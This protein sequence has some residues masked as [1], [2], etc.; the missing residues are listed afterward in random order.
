MQ[1]I[2]RAYLAPLTVQEMIDSTNPRC[3]DATITVGKH[4]TI[5]INR[6]FMS[7]ISPVF[8]AAFGPD[9]KESQTGIIDIKDFNYETV[10]CAIDY[11]YGQA[12]EKKTAT[13][14]TDMLRFYDKYD[15]QAA[16]EK[17]ETWLMNNMTIENFPPTAA[18]AWQYSRDTLQ[19]ECG[20]VYHD[21]ITALACRPDFA[22]LDPIVLAGIVQ[23]GVAASKVP[24]RIPKC[25]KIG[26]AD[27][28]KPM[29]LFRRFMNTIRRNPRNS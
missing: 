5:Q 25:N 19:T 17:L 22:E 12:F 11:C 8:C 1:W 23:A 9:T 4:N 14:V 2:E 7:M 18:Y 10:K 6:G 13:E 20:M 24:N 3:S 29:N 21:N 26:M 28:P 27:P 15:I 16:I